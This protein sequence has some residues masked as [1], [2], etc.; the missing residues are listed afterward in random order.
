[1]KTYNNEEYGNTRKNNGYA[2]KF[3][4]GTMI[5]WHSMM[6]FDKLSNSKT[7]NLFTSDINTWTFPE[8]FSGTGGV[9]VTTSCTLANMW[10]DVTS[11]PSTTSVNVAVFSTIEKTTSDIKPNVFLMAIGRWK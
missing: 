8:E 1:M 10:S 7:G 11:T 5:C 9:V 3:P 6:G 4:D 2:V